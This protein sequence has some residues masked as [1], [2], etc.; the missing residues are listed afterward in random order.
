[1]RVTVDFPVLPWKA[2]SLK[3]RFRVRVRGFEENFKKVSEKM[4]VVNA[5]FEMQVE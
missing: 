4:R 5:A 2:R 1:M 3:S